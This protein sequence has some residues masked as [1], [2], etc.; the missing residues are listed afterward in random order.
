M[1]TPL[2]ELMKY[3]PTKVDKYLAALQKDLDIRVS[4]NNKLEKNVK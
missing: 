3:K 1:D 2:V 4:I